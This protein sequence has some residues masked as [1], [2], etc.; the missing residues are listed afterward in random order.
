VVVYNV[1]RDVAVGFAGHRN[2]TG[3]L[4]TSGYFNIPTQK[5]V[6]AFEGTLKAVAIL[7]MRC[8]EYRNWSN[9]WVMKTQVLQ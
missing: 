3:P 1:V 9:M 6:S 4:F 5:I 2:Y 8:L 7:D